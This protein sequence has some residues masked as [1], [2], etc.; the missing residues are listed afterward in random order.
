M[1]VRAVVMLVQRTLL[2][3]VEVWMVEILLPT[4]SVLAPKTVNT[5]LLP[6][7]GD[8][9][10]NIPV[11]AF[12]CLVAELVRSTAEIL[13]VMSIDAFA[14]VV[15]VVFLGRKWTP[16]GLEMEHVEVSVHVHLVQKVDQNVVF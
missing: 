13:H 6:V 4:M 15:M 10:I 9:L 8:F 5:S 14:S 1:I 2:L 16:N 3:F 11:L 12:S 7:H